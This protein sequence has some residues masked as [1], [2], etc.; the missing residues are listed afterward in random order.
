[1][2]QAQLLGNFAMVALFGFLDAAQVGLQFL[3]VAPG[4]AIDALQ[5]FVAGIA[6]PVGAGHLG[7]LE[8]L[9]LAGAGHV[10][11]AA[12]VHPGA[13]AVDANLLALGQFL[14]DLDLVVLPHIAEFFHRVLTAHHQALYRQVV[15]DDLRH[16]LFD[17]LEVFRRKTMAGGEV[18]VEAVFDDR[19]DGD[20]GAGVQFLHGHGQQ[21]GGGMTND[22]Q[23]FLIAVGDDRQLGVIFNE[24]GGIHLAAVHFA[25]QGR[26]GEAG[27]DIGGHV[28]NRNRMVEGPL[29]T[30][31]Q[32]NNWHG[33]ESLSS[34]GPYKGSRVG[35]MSEAVRSSQQHHTKAPHPD[36]HPTS[37]EYP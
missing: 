24:V 21:V 23:A 9:E 26:L 29:G 2:E 35:E 14:N 8:G 17:F 15:V 27:A 4:G 25:G 20:L 30:V 10:G 16:A 37:S 6:A 5:H 32:G 12:Q 22:L 34:G 13:L 7:Q 11:T 1:M 33:L 3:A 36:F 19:A 18:V 31:G 28:V